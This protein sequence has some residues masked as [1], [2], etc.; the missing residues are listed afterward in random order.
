MNN[1][2]AGMVTTIPLIAFTLVP[3]A[4][5]LIAKRIG[6]E[7]TLLYSLLL[8]IVGLLFLR[9]ISSV[10]ALM[11]GMAFMGIAISWECSTSRSHQTET[12]RQN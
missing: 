6:M 3:P 7:W 11:T 4:A 5:P 8:L 12:S 9:S 1:A 2:V 10:T